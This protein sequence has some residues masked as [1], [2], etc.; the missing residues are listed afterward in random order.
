MRV[1]IRLYKRHDLDLLALYFVDDYNFT[2]EFKKAIRG[3]IHGKPMKNR[4]PHMEN[5]KNVYSM[6]SKVSFHIQL[7]DDDKDI[8]DFIRSIT[9]GRRNN[10][11]KNIFRNSF[12]VIEAPYNCDS[13]QNNWN[14]GGR[15]H[16]I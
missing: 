3:Y 1:T 15:K 11:L 6:P 7:K 4:I 13:E 12:P 9:R 16:D 8:L 14:L 10:M 5:M 2:E